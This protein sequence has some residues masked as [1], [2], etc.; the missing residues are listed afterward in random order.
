MQRMIER[1]IVFSTDAGRE[2]G[3]N[4]AEPARAAGNAVIVSGEPSHIHIPRPS[5]ALPADA[6]PDLLEE[7]PR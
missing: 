7:T 2:W 1:R 6:Q 4:L 3:I 5:R